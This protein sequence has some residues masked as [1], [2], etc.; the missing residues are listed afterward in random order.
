[1]EE[2]D[3]AFNW[4]ILILSTVNG[5]L[6][7]LPETI[8]AKKAMAGFLIPPFFVLAVVWF[9]SYLMLRPNLRTILK[10]YAWFYAFFMILTFTIIFTEI[11]YELDYARVFSA[12]SI[13]L[14]PWFVVWL[15]VPFAF[16]DLLIRPKYRKICKDSRLLNSRK[17]LMLLYILAFVTFQILN[18]PLLSGAHSYFI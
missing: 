15:V 1:L 16:F 12:S 13:L 8:E 17:L 7:S 4:L 10:T 5:T 9:L 2:I 6:I 18:L 11:A 3:E 14:V